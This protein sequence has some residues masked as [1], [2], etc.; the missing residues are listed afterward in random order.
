VTYTVTAEDASTT[1]D[2]VVSILV[3]ANKETDITQ[4]SLATQMAASTIDPVAHVVDIEV[5]VGT[6][7]SLLAPGISVSS[8]ATIDPASGVYRDFT[9]DVPYTVT[10]EDGIT[11]Q[12]W[13][14]RVTTGPKSLETDITGFSI[15]QLIGP[16]LIDYSS[17][18]VVGTVAFGTD[19][20]A[21]VPTINVSQGAT[22][23]PASG[24]ITDFSAPVSYT[25]TAQDGTTRQDWE[26][27]IL[28]LPNTETDITEFSMVEQTGPSSISLVDHTVE[29]EVSAGTDLITLLPAIE[30]SPG[31]SID[32]A[33]GMSNDFT[34]TVDYLVTAEDGITSQSWK[35][36][37]SREIPLGIGDR[38]SES[39][40][41]FPNPASEF[42][43]IELTRETNIRLHD[44]M[45]K[46]HYSMDH[47]NGDQS[48]NVSE[49]NEGIYIVSLL[50]EDGSLQQRKL[51][52]R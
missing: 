32:P 28:T 48:I 23:D 15:P 42:V 7:L 30:V 40:R 41:V 17:H 46:L 10:A 39:I 50:M 26:I 49:Y 21:R 6:D 27:S 4:F 14:V 5:A 1:Q 52:I 11:T 33:K 3:E 2:W 51:I 36:N 43:F 8:G 9:S 37:V 24:V 22:I 20:S 31:A 35:I 34:N 47:A 16:A 38:T 25:V 12:A 19:L 44:L 45:G 18:T 13:I 29:I